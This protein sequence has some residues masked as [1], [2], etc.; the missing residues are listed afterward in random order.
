MRGLAVA[1]GSGCALPPIISPRSTA[2]APPAFIFKTISRHEKTMQEL[3]PVS[4]LW[5]CLTLRVRGTLHRV[6]GSVRLPLHGPGAEEGG[7]AHR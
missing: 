3:A 1:P 7:G 5:S 4:T 2:S 6:P